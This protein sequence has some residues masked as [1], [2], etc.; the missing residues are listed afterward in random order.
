MVSLSSFICSTHAYEDRFRVDKQLLETLVCFETKTLVL[1]VSELK[2][3]ENSAQSR[4]GDSEDEPVP[5]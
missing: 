2:S 3:V 1:N 5:Q 4:Q